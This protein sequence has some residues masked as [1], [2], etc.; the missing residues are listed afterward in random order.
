MNPTKNIMID[1]NL[2]TGDIAHHIGLSLIVLAF[3]SLFYQKYVNGK[4]VYLPGHFFLIYAI[5]CFFLSYSMWEQHSHK[6]IIFLEGL[7]GVLGLYFYI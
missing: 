6:L 7:L 2:A 5:G 3:L 4:K 1:A